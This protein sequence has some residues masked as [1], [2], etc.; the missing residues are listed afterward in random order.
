MDIL[1][2]SIDDFICNRLYRIDCDRITSRGKVSRTGKQSAVLQ[3]SYWGQNK[4]RSMEGALVKIYES[5]QLC[6]LSYWQQY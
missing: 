5:L 2:N 1:K 3:K 4:G 6:Y